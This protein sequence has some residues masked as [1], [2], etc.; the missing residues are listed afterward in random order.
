VITQNGVFSVE[1][2]LIEQINDHTK[3]QK[4]KP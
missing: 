3:I 2:P 1:I 4:W